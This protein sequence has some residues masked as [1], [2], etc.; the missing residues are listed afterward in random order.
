MPDEDEPAAREL[1]TVVT[2]QGAVVPML[3]PLELANA[4]VF[5]MRSRRVNAAQRAIALDALRQLPVEIDTETLT[6]VWTETLALA[7]KLRLT[8]YDACYLELA[9]RRRLPL[10][11]LDKDLRAAARKLGVPLLN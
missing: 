10:A 7:D 2:D 6:N 3:W 9:Q 1:Q 4:L 11:T 8:I 5:A